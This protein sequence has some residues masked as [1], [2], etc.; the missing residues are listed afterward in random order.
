METNIQIEVEQ[1]AND[2]V[3]ANENVELSLSDLDMVGGGQVAVV[4]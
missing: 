3:K 4:Y 1:L 2:Q